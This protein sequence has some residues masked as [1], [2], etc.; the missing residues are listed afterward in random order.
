VLSASVPDNLKEPPISLGFR[1]D[2][3]RGL[4]G[5][6]YC[7][8][9]GT[10]GVKINPEATFTSKGQFGDSEKIMKGDIYECEGSRGAIV[11]PVAKLNDIQLSSLD[12]FCED[13]NLKAIDYVPRIF[14]ATIFLKNLKTGADIEKIKV[15]CELPDQDKKPLGWDEANKKPE[16]RQYEC[17]SADQK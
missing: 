6:V 4:P 15:V 9:P 16:K 7:Q 10:K 14:E 11:A 1:I 3:S 8:K 12:K 5:V 13:P 17:Y 2:A